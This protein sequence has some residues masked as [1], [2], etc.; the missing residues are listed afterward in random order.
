NLTHDLRE[1]GFQLFVVGQRKDNEDGLWIASQALQQIGLTVEE[2]KAE[3][4]HSTA[5]LEKAIDE[6][7][8]SDLLTAFSA[9]EE[10]SESEFQVVDYVR[11]AKE[12]GDILDE[13]YIKDEVVNLA[14]RNLNKL[15]SAKV[16]A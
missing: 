2:L 5:F 16:F 13:Q 8:T 7:L 9:T 14:V 4:D 3:V 6:K 15:L 10:E 1:H 12:L 11:L